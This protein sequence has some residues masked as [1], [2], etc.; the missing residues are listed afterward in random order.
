M[1]LLQVSTGQHHCPDYLVL[2]ANVPLSRLAA[3]LPP[4][5]VC[6]LSDLRN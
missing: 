1:Q 5:Q 2:V 6:S 3:I 4:I